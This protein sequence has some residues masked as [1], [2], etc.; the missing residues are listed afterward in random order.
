VGKLKAGGGLAPILAGLQAS[1][2]HDRV[3]Q[4]AIEALAAVDAREGLNAAIRYAQPGAYGRTRPTAIAAIGTLAHHDKDIALKALC[5]L[6]TDRE[7]RSWHAAGSALATLADA[8]IV[9]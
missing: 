7:S 4:A 9:P 6:L 8:R 1:S 2:Q 3:R 5:D